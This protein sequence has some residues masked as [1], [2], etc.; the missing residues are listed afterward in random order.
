MADSFTQVVR[1]AEAMLE[2]VV[3]GAEVALWWTLR[4]GIPQVS[5]LH[6][7]PRDGRPWADPQQA[8]EA[9]RAGTMLRGTPDSAGKAIWSLPVQ[10]HGGGQAVLQLRA[11]ASVFPRMEGDAA[12]V[13]SVELVARRVETLIEMRLLKRSVRRH[14]RSERVQK[15]LFRIADL[16]NSEIRLDDFYAAVHAEI[17]QLLYAKNFFIAL[18]VENDTAFDFPYAVDEYDD[19]ETYFQRKPIG[20]GSTAYVLR[21]G[22]P[23]LMDAATSTRLAEAG[24]IDLIGSPAHAWMGVPLEVDGRV[25]GVLVVQSYTKGIG[26]GLLEL[27]LLAFVAQHIAA[28]LQ[29]RQAADSL[30]AAYADLQDQIEELHRTQDELIENEKMASLGR[31]V[32]GVAH[33]INTPLGIGVTAASHLDEIFVKIERSMQANESPETAKSLAS[34]RRCVQL[35]LSNLDKAAQLVRSF[36][37]VAVDQT[38]EVRRVVAMSAFLNEVL[39]SLH[40]RLKATRLR[41]EI[42]CDE[43]LEMDTLPGALYQIISNLVL[44][45]VVH[46]FD[47]GQA[48]Q[49]RV[50]AAHISDGFE[51]AVSDDGKGMPEDVRLRVFEPFF[52]TRRGSG[53]TGLGLHLVYN[54]VVKLLGGTIGCTSIQGEGTRFVIRLP[55]TAASIE[56]I[57]PAQLP[58]A[59]QTGLQTS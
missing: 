40:P 5:K 3:V 23:L 18:L 34:A 41:V 59:P 49:I 28:A 48:G 10:G 37:Q 7:A 21:K 58:P 4:P 38:S 43:T 1:V 27:E 54:L 20:H 22:K 50:S 24:E 16:S 17:G 44:N 29:R 26:Y 35:I 19:R 36:K 53:G 57:D 56:A 30:K 52:T 13:Q 11:D 2:T 25:K 9:M 6:C 31:L 45:S 12:L 47:D 46:A 32:A 51:I 42:D 14:E 15:A 8:C 33:E 39:T 55:S